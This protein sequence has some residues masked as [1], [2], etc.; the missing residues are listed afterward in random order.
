MNCSSIQLNDLPNENLVLIFKN[1]NNINLLY[2]II[3]V[4]KRFNEIAHDSMFTNCLTLFGYLT[5]GYIYPLPKLMLDRFCLQILP[6]IHHK[7]NWLDL[8]PLTMKRILLSANYPNLTGLGISNIEKQTA[9][10]LLMDETLVH[11]FKNQISSLV[12]ETINKYDKANLDTRLFTCIFDIFTNLKYL[13]FDPDFICNQ[14]ISFVVSPPT[15]FSSTL[16]ELDVKVRFIEDCLYFLDGRFNQ[17]QTFYVDIAL[18]YL[19]SVSKINKPKLPNL[20]CFSLYCLS[21]INFYDEVISMLHRMSNLEELSLYLS[22][23]C[24]DRF[25]DGNDLKQNIIN[26]MLRLN[27]FHFDFRLNFTN[28]QIISCVNYFLEAKQGYCHIYSYPFTARSYEN[29]ANNF[30]GGLFTCVSKVTL[31]DEYPFEHE[32]FIRIAQSFPFMKFLTIMNRKPQNDKQCRKLKNNNQDLLIINY[33]HL[34]Y[35]HFKDTHDD[36]V[37]QFLLDTKTILP[38]DVNIY[39]DYKTLK[40]VTHNFRRNATQINCYKATYQCFDRIIRFPKY[41]KDYFHDIKLHIL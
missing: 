8:E 15:M 21:G 24:N 12:I 16:L 23:N 35:I 13:N 26:Y 38:Y 28:N 6:E 27:L 3:G 2:S 32:F 19:R 39:V 4:N 37:E 7:I 9:L 10:D 20:Q 17:L 31:F 5:N 29:I 30:S 40:R 22:V 18:P 36:Y 41:F 33:P 14:Q 1:L 11:V 25:I 34:K